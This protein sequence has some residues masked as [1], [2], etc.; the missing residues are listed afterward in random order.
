MDRRERKTTLEEVLRTA[1][2][3]MQARVWTAI[4]GVVQTYNPALQTCSV[5]PAVNG[6]QRNPDGSWTSKQMPLLLDCPVQF[7]GGGG[8]TLTFPIAPGDEV[9]VLLSS[10]CIDTWFESGFAEGG[11]V[12]LANAQNDPPEWRMH[13]LSDGFVI[14]SVHSMPRALTVDPVSACLATDDGLAYIK[15]NPVTHSID[16][17]ASGGITMNGLTID[18]AGITTANGIVLETHTHTSASPGSPT[19]PPLP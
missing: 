15:L 11:S 10:R 9:I 13:N 6:R 3:S 14:P 18:A 12:D 8:L 17:V 7:A 1:Y 16:M 5:Q 19:S 2:E 4:V